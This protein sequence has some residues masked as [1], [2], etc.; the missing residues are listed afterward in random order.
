VLSSGTSAYASGTQRPCFFGRNPGRK[1]FH[2]ELSAG[3]SGEIRTP[4]PCSRSKGVSEQV[5][6]E[7]IQLFESY[8]QAS[9]RTPT[10]HRVQTRPAVL[11][12]RLPSSERCKNANSR[13]LTDI[14]A[15]RRRRPMEPIPD[16]RE[17]VTRHAAN[18]E[19]DD[20]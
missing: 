3:R 4:D 16:K 15:L 18:K 10:T 20:H 19:R 7:E 1:A 2:N 11:V 8:I 5:E 12:A 14:E 13:T 9:S 17:H 6:S